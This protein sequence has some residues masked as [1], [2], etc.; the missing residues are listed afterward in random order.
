[1]G[2]SKLII[3]M[4]FFTIFC[5]CLGLSLN[6]VHY[7]PGIYEGSGRGFRD[8][9]LV[10]VFVSASGIE[11]IELLE[12]HEDTGETTMEELREIILE[13]GFIPDLWDIDGISGATMSS[14][15]FLEAVENALSKAME[16]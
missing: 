15:G 8:S 13:T 16:P 2:F 6:A 11:D 14:R 4:L 3:L 7:E 1:M 5:A 9:I 10:R 12:H